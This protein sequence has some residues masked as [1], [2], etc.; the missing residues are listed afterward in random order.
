MQFCL[1]ALQYAPS[2][3]I[4]FLYLSALRTYTE[5]DDACDKALNF[6]MCRNKI[7]FATKLTKTDE[8]SLSDFAE[9]TDVDSPTPISTH[10]AKTNLNPKK[11]ASEKHSS[12]FDMLHKS[13]ASHQ[14]LEM[15][16]YK[17]SINLLTG[18]LKT[19]LNFL[20]SVLGLKPSRLPQASSVL[21]PCD[22]MVLWMT[23]IHVLEHHQLPPHLYSMSDENPG[24][25]VSKSVSLHWHKDRTLRTSLD[26]LIK[27][28]QNYPQ[29]PIFM[30][31]DGH[32]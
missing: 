30:S 31:D 17:T 18:R 8:A 26:W 11:D 14:A 24:K 6:L 3:E 25:L 2:Y 21:S 32:P 29:A 1:T 20:Q 27:Q 12:T 13:K 28:R 9:D 16:V 5:K 4:W 15:I 10:N 23:Y 19:T 22:H 7:I